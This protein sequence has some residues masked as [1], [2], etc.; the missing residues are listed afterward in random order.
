VIARWHLAPGVALV[1]VGDGLVTVRDRD[2]ERW[3]W[4]GCADQPLRAR[5]ITTAHSSRYLAEEPACTLELELADPRARLITIVG[6]DAHRHEHELRE[7]R[8]AI[9]SAS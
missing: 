3:L 5:P 9:E 2:A 7:L 1:D 6:A 8:A 4:F